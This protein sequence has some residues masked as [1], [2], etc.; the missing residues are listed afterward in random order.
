VLVERSK[1]EQRYDAVLMVMMEGFRVTEVASHFRNIQTH[2]SSQIIC[3]L[4]QERDKI[5]RSLVCQICAHGM[6]GLAR[7]NASSWPRSSLRFSRRSTSPARL[8]NY[9]N[10]K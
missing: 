1:M 8:M 3:V 4:R 10:L 5:L 2:L 6:D 9:R 7:L